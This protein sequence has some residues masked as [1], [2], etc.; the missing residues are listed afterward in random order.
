MNQQPVEPVP[1]PFKITADTPE[2]AKEWGVPY[3]PTPDQAFDHT[4]KVVQELKERGIGVTIEPRTYEPEQLARLT[5]K[6]SDPSRVKHARWCGVQ[7]RTADLTPVFKAKAALAELGI[8]F[9]TGGGCGVLDWE[10]DWS[11]R[12]GEPVKPC[13]VETATRPMI[14]K[15]IMTS[16]QDGDKAAI[17][18]TREDLDLMIEAFERAYSQE[19]VQISRFAAFLADLRQ[20]RDATFGPPKA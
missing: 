4:L 16:L 1:A 13:T 3:E 17:L 11:F 2:L 7:F 6:Y 8:H 5:A 14:D 15:Q 18:C 10:L 12:Y 9:D 19:P 20:F